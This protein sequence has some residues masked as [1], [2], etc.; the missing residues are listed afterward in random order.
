MP[1]PTALNRCR[2]MG[3]LRIALFACLSGFA[4]QLAA[5]TDQPLRMWVPNIHVG[6][7]NFSKIRRIV[8]AMEQR[9]GLNIDLNVSNDNETLRR[10]CA[11]Y[12]AD[13][14]ILGELEAVYI[15][16]NYGYEVIA[17]TQQVFYLYTLKEHK[18]TGPAQL[19][20]I[21][22]IEQ[23]SGRLIAGIELSPAAGNRDYFGF[24]SQAS[25]ILALLNGDIDA[26]VALHSAV[27]QLN[28]SLRQ[29]IAVVRAFKRPARAYFLTSPRLP[30]VAK[31]RLQT[32]YF[33]DDP[34]I[35]D[36][37]QDQFGL[38]A[39]RRPRSGDSPSAWMQT[40]KK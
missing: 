35:S 28:S 14:V 36:I 32:M 31:Q 30:L 39:L 19:H 7:A 22:Y 29:R 37:F 16:E 13:H 21:G 4:G 12:R 8:T 27:P 33:S 17:F 9:T 34:F 18:T 26:L 38:G 20:R 3:Y 10:L 25:A 11:E 5:I 24:P 1:V 2:L 15:S 40:L 6:P 23:T